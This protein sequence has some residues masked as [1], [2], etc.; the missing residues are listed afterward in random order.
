[1]W[2]LLEI[3]AAIVAVLRPRSI[4]YRTTIV[5]VLICL[6]AP[7]AWIGLIL[8]YVFGFKLGWTPIADYCNFIPSHRIRVCSGPL[9]WAYHLILPWMA[10]MFL[11]AAI[12]TRFIRA[13]MLETMSEDYVRT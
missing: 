1:V 12:Y 5:L 2:T 8:A 6:S 13:S 9:R 10:F 3:P 7:A 4:L 11:N